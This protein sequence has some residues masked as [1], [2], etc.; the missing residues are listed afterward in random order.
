MF[1]QAAKAQSFKLAAEQLHVT[2][3]AV[4]QQI[5]TLE[6]HLEVALFERLTREVVLTAEGRSLLPY[7]EQAFDALELGVDLLQ[8]DPFPNRLSLTVLPS[9]ASRWL[10]PRLGLFQQ[11]QPELTIHLSPALGLASFDDGQLDLA[12]R[13]GLG[14]YP[15]LLSKPLMSDHLVP[16]CH[17]S[18]IDS[19]QEIIG[20]LAKLP[21]L[22]DESPDTEG[23]WELFEQQL[24]VSLSDAA[25]RLHVSDSTMLVEAVL[26][27]QGLSMVRFSLVYELLARGMLI[28][29]I[30]IYLDARYGFYLVAPERHFSRQ[31]VQLFETWLRA[32]T[33]QID[34]AWQL[35]SRGEPMLLTLP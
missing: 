3:A 7:V 28:C 33:A 29:P 13:F 4:S 32:E 17:P 1:R 9:F 21:M 11:Q 20:Q 25:S 6:A 27:A 5:K 31:K 24:G 16:V 8:A 18:L 34:A 2:Q 12:I 26:S 15:G 14:D 22:S 35:F 23:I 10:V 19:R 30:D